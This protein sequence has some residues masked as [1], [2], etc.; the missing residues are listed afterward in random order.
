MV[1]KFEKGYPC[2]NILFQTPHRAI[3]WQNGQQVRD[4]DL[5]D[6]T[7]LI[8][9]LDAFFAYRPPEYTEW[10]EAVAHFKNRVPDIGSE[11]ADLIQKETGCQ[12]SL[13]R[14]I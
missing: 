3:L 9:I 1:R 6:P 10:E 13:Y 8:K 12:P 5:T 2:D 14:G 4:A 11:L 7:Q